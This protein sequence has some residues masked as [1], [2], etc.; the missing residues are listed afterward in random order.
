[1]SDSDILSKDELTA[2]ST[3]I[4]ST[5]D[6]AQP[7]VTKIQDWSHALRA[8]GLVQA[9]GELVDRDCGGMCV[10]GVAFSTFLPE[11]WARYMNEEEAGL[12]ATSWDNDLGRALDTFKISADP[13]WDANDQGMTLPQ[14]ADVLDQYIAKAA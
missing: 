11:E 6:Y 2:L 13:F 5:L 10:L 7:S 3:R 8:D 1:M 9:C 4:L 14:I 12:F